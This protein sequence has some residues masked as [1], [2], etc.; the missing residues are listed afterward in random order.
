LLKKLELVGPVVAEVAAPHQLLSS[1]VKRTHSICREHIL[2]IPHHTSCSAHMLSFAP[3]VK[4]THCS[5]NNL[6]KKRERDSLQYSETYYSSKREFVTFETYYSSKR[7]FV[8]FE[9]YYS[10][11]R[12]FVTFETYYSSKR[13]FITFETYYSSKREF[14][15]T[16]VKESSLRL[17]LL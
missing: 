3:E 15:T 16:A 1:Y 6:N 17:Q 7:E 2:L 13:E 12:E 8:T 9:T 5:S 14:V 11:K 4:E 10:S